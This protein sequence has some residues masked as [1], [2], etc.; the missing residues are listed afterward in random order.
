MTAIKVFHRMNG[1]VALALAIEGWSE[2]NNKGLGDG[3]INWSPDMA[4]IVGY[5]M[6]GREELAVG[7][8][9]FDHRP[10]NHILWAQQVF[11]QEAFRGQGVYTAMFTKLVEI[12]R[13]QGYVAI[14]MGTHIKNAAMRAV[15]QKT[16]CHEEA[17]ILRF[18]LE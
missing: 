10:G 3:S 15:G 18:N 12:A 14:E 17:V 7:V 2:V 16:G 1:T 11:V 5:A 13:E 9:T 8:I 6:N 4:A